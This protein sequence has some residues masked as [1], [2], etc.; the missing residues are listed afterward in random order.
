[1]W[2]NTIIKTKISEGKGREMKGREMK[3][4]ARERKGNETSQ[5]IILLLIED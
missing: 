4:M 1:M 5:I 2:H 3:G